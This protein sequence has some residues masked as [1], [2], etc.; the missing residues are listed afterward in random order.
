M[1]APTPLTVL[2]R[3]YPAARGLQHGPG[4]DP[5]LLQRF[6]PDQLVRLGSAAGPQSQAL[7]RTSAEAVASIVRGELGGPPR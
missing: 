7:G 5:V 6:W 2:S 1:Q 3:A 4:L